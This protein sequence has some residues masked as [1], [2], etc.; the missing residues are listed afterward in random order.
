MKYIAISIIKIYQIILSPDKGILVKMGIKRASVC[1]FYPTCSIYTIDA[2]KKYGVVKG[3][4]LGIKRIS[5]CHP[6]QKKH[7]DILK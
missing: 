1:V 3:F 7:I 4:I 6:W 2:I 5:R